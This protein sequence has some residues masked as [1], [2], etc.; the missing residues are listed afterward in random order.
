MYIYIYIYIYITSY[1]YFQ[2]DTCILGPTPPDSH[3]DLHISISHCPPYPQGH[4]HPSS[5][6]SEHHRPPP[7]TMAHHPLFPWVM[8]LLCLSRCAN[9]LGSV[10]APG[11]PNAHGQPS[12]NRICASGTPM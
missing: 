11:L 7:T 10:H 9:A 5:T 2:A 8:L 6:L 12:Q 3:P 4:S 1:I